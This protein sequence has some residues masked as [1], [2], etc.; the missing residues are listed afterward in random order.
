MQRTE[1]INASELLIKSSIFS[2]SNTEKHRR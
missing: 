1:K 2:F